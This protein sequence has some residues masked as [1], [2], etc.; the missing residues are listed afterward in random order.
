MFKMIQEKRRDE[1]CN[2]IHNGKIE[3]KHSFSEDINASCNDQDQPL[4]CFFTNANNFIGKIEEFREWVKVCMLAAV[5]ETW[6]RDY[7]ADCE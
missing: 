4:K 1:P 3:S 5:I 2:K 6:A 7:T